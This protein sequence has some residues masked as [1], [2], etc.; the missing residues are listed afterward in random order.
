MKNKDGVNIL[1]ELYRVIFNQMK[2][3]NLIFIFFYYIYFF[4]SFLSG[5]FL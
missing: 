5:V 4:N 3:N 1:K 2:Y